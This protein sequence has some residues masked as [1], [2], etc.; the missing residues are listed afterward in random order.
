MPEQKLTL[1][2]FRRFMNRAKEFLSLVLL[3]LEILKLILDLL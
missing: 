3:G 2:M 1:A